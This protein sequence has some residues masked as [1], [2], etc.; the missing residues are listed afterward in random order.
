MGAAG[1]GPFSEAAM[2]LEQ[3]NFGMIVFS[4][5]VDRFEVADHRVTMSGTA[6]SITTINDDVAE[7]AL[8]QFTVEAVDGGAP[9]GDRFSLTLHGAKLMFDNHTFAPGPGSGIA[10]GEI[11]IRP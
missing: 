8:Y 6:R 11:V 4:V 10:S 7:N 9:E 2:Q 5:T 3:V 1:P